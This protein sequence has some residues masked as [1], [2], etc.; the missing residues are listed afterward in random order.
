VWE[1]ILPEKYGLEEEDWG[2][3][4]DRYEDAKSRPAGI[5]AAIRYIE[6]LGE[7]S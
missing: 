4:S 7:Q 2:N 3:I 6:S 1:D 5:R